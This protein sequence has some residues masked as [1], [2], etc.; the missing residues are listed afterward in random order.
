MLTRQVTF[1]ETSRALLAGTMGP[2]AHR[3]STACLHHSLDNKH[4]KTNWLPS[5]GAVESTKPADKDTG[6]PPSNDHPKSRRLT[7]KQLSDMAFG[8]REMSKRLS[9]IKLK[10]NVRNIFIQMKTDDKVLPG[11]AAMLVTW[12]LGNPQYTVYVSARSWGY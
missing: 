1:N 7:K 10:L 8:I 6:T 12:L 11:K 9:H 5:Q 4:E 3:N 2:L